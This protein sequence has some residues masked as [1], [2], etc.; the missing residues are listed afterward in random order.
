MRGCTR[1]ADAMEHR[2]GARRILA[3]LAV[4]MA[5]LLPLVGLAVGQT[6][7]YLNMNE[8]T[9][10][11]PDGD[12]VDDGNSDANHIRILAPAGEEH[13]WIYNRSL[14]P[15]Q[16][17]GRATFNFSFDV[18]ID[19][20]QDYYRG[21]N[22][23]L[24]TGPNGTIPGL[25]IFWRPNCNTNVDN[26]ARIEG[27]DGGLIEQINGSE[28][29][30]GPDKQGVSMEYIHATEELRIRL[31]EDT[32]R[33]GDPHFDET[34]AW[35]NST[36]LD[37]IAIFDVHSGL[38][39]GDGGGGIHISDATITVDGKA[40]DLRIDG[41]PTDQI[42]RNE[43]VSYDAVVE[44][45]DGGE[46]TVTG[47]ATERSNRT[48]ILTV[49]DAG[50]AQAQDAAGHVKVNATYQGLETSVNTTVYNDTLEDIKYVPDARA[51]TIVLG[52]WGIWS[53]LAI[54]AFCALGCNR[55]W[56]E[57]IA[58][59]LFVAGTSAMWLLDLADIYLPMAA[60]LVGGAMIFAEQVPGGN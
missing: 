17:F 38:K 59:M 30:S 55:I 36:D 11:D 25:N 50:T 43:T 39:E 19:L 23:G 49:D 14:G 6:A 42:N 32:A 18:Q 9:I 24:S 44:L 7:T 54:A 35:D 33:T 20:Y 8:V 15:G 47:D 2:P 52:N 29:G 51:A 13:G 56:A 41:I 3:A 37:E 26:C 16:A 28:D 57:E 40:E 22:I 12:L 53:L 27:P 4:V 48:S 5:L 21:A 45:S 60:L 46:M 58:I 10:N 1:N 31:W 34:F